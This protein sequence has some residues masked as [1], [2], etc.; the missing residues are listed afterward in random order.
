M[1]PLKKYALTQTPR[2]K[3][4][5]L[6]SGVAHVGESSG[7]GYA[8]FSFSEDFVDAV[9]KALPQ[10]LSREEP[11]YL[12]VLQMPNTWRVFAVYLRREKGALLWETPT[13]PEWLTATRHR[14]HRTRPLSS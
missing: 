6:L 10:G 8:Y 11:A 3:K 7:K 12:K 2:P 13:R 5:P 9:G 1:R 4:H 14:T